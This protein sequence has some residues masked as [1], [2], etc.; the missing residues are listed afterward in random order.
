M[1]LRLAHALAGSWLVFVTGCSP[2]IPIPQGTP[3]SELVLSDTNPGMSF[4]SFRLDGRSYRAPSLSF[5]IPAGKHSVG[6]GYVV[7]ITDSCDPEESFCSST[8]MTGRCSGE[9]LAEP[10]ERYRLLV[11]TRS[12]T[13]AGTVQKRAAGALYIGQGEGIVASLTCENTGSASREGAVGI[14]TF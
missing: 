4:D 12:G 13:P 8:V 9:F 11:D 14:A 3:S 6:V 10:N 7:R 2:I 1:S 5:D